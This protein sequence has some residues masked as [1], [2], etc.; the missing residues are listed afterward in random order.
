MAHRD[1]RRFRFSDA[2]RLSRPECIAVMVIVCGLAIVDLIGFFVTPGADAAR[3]ALSIATTLTFLVFIWSPL[4]ATL[5]L[6]ACVSLSFFLDT[7]TAGLVAGAIAAGLVMR[8][9]NT[10]LVVG[11]VG[12]LLIANAAFLLSYGSTEN[13]PTTVAVTLMIATVAGG[14]GFALRAAYARGYR[15]EHALAVQAEREREAVL[16]E[17]RWIAG[18]L[19]DSIAHHLTVIAM[20]VQLIDDDAVRE[21]SQSAIQ[22]SARKALSDLRF[23]I[24]MAEEA[25]RGTGVPSGDL[26]AAIDEAREEF[27]ATGHDVVCIGDPSDE[28]IPRGAEI[29]LARIVR[30]SATN[31]LK[32]AGPG[33]VRFVLQIG[34]ESISLEIHSPLPATP[35][36]DLPSTGTGLNRM[37]ERVL[38]VSGEFSAGPLDG[39]WLVAVRLPIAR[40]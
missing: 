2:E 36:R 1:T 16:A 15:L 39:A 6:A 17:R 13:A 20:H 24:Q 28:N 9:G 23:V 5:T 25:P 11:Y 38:G 30:E 18:E 8:I 29:I 35:R 21:T 19:H 7:T 32:Y 27:E 14:V 10:R 31:V 34:A 22:T 26:S 12:G 3:T 33:E 37:A 4:A 40:G